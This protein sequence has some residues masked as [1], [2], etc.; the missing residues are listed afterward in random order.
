MQSFNFSTRAPHTSGMMQLITCLE[1]LKSSCRLTYWSPLA[2][3][4]S[5]SAKL[6]FTQIAFLNAM[7][8]CD[9][10]FLQSN[11]LKIQI[12]W[13]KLWWNYDITGWPTENSSLPTNLNRWNLPCLCTVVNSTTASVISFVSPWHCHLQGAFLV[14]S[15]RCSIDEQSIEYCGWACCF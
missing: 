14:P 7:S 15:E 3:K 4:L 2:K 11:E 5:V 1:M 13:E 6:S 10:F 12:H 8:F 9:I